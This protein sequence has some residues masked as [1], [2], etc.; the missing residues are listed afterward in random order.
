M[1]YR[2]QSTVQNWVSEFLR[3]QSDSAPDIS[4]LEQVYPEGRDIGM[5]TVVLNTA[6][7]SAYLRPVQVDDAPR[8]SVHF[9]ARDEGFDLDAS[10]VLTLAADLTVLGELCAYLQDRT[11]ATL[12][13]G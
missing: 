12:Q 4:V 3:S 8:W 6:P 9:E 13:A 1:P 11:D 5:V 10:G 2:D 7:T